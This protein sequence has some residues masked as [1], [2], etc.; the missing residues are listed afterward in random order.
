MRQAGPK[1]LGSHL[2]PTADRGSRISYV[3]GEFVINQREHDRLDECKLL[4]EIGILLA[5]CLRHLPPT[6]AVITIKPVTG[7]HLDRSL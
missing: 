7:S 2:H 5:A 6:I 4:S 3:W 1:V